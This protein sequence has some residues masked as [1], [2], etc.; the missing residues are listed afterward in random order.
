MLDFLCASKDIVEQAYF[1]PALSQHTVSL[2]KA[3]KASD[4]LSPRYWPTWFAIGLM[5]LVAMLPLRAIE[6]LGSLLG[7]LLYWALPN[8][9]RI[10]E[11]NLQI[12][13]PEHSQQQIRKQNKTCFH[14]LGIAA[15]ELALSWWENHKLLAL[16][17]IEGLQHLQQAQQLGK[18]VIILTAHFT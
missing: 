1:T 18:G 11:I 2:I 9:R 4:Y 17:E 6:I 12:A 15:F 16:C 10:G 7:E 13:F 8:R 14:N 5:R 3:V